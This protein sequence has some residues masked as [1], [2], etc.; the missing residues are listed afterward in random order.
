MLGRVSAVIISLMVVSTLGFLLGC[1][2]SGSS[3]PASSTAPYTQVVTIAATGGSMQS[4]AGGKPFSAPLAVSVAVNG[5][6]FSGEKVTFSAPTSG[7]SGTFA[8]GSTTEDDI[9]DAKG[10]ATSS[11]FTANSV[12]GAYMVTATVTGAKPL[13]FS[14]TNIA[15]TPFAFSMSGQDASGGYYALA[16]AIVLDSDGNVISG[17]QDYNDGG[18]GY[19]SPEPKGD[20]ITGGTLT[21]P[22]GSRAGQGTLTLNT[23]NTNLGLNADGVEV[24]AVQFVNAKH[25]LITQFDGFAT[26]SGSLDLQ[27]LPNALDGNYAFAVSGFDASDTPVAYGGV[28]SASGVAA[29]GVVDTNDAD[30]LGVTMDKAFTWTIAGPDGYGRGTLK[31]IKVGG[32][33]VTLNYYVIG[34]EAVR[35]IDVDAYDSAAGSAFGQGAGSFSNAS[36]GSSVLAMNG[37]VLAQFGAL[38]QF[39]TSN[40]GSSPASFAGVGDESEPANGVISTETAKINGSYSVASDGYGSLT[41][42][43]TNG[44]YP[45][46]GDITTLGIYLTDPAMNLN[47]PNNPTG[48]GGGLVVDLD[49]GA[50][51]GV[52]LP[53]LTGIIVPQTDAATASADFAGNYAAAWQN[54]D[55]EGCSCEFDMVAQGTMAAGGQLSLTGMVSDPALSLGEADATS[56]SNTFTGTPLADSKNP[57]RYT[58]LTGKDSLATMID[59]APGPEFDMV[60]YQASG[61]QLFW[62]DYDN[63]EVT[64]SLGPLEQQGSLTGIPAGTSA[65]ADPPAKPGLRRQGFVRH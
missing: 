55:N 11:T 25:A 18:F 24:F 19:A 37:S 58:M 32:S 10:V 38:G 40:T 6:T 64:V 27:T 29:S 51:V 34:P 3:N 53:G 15:V 26:S 48:G 57:G 44:N 17:E 5:A 4:A 54:F 35:L 21:I 16:G 46:L 43:T 8:N 62:L 30:N 47:D 22:S 63:S 28:F 12:G 60:I 49:S 2:S 42:N 9:T 1:S 61:G 41:F 52:A 59:G 7:A 33:G 13:S 50:Q 20:L 31:G 23:N 56:A 36:L 65:S 45:G 39:T 14:L